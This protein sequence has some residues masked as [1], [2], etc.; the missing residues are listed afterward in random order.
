MPLDK[1]GLYLKLDCG[2]SAKT[3]EAYVSDIK[4]FVIENHTS[5]ERLKPID[6]QNFL[7]ALAQNGISARSLARKLSALRMFFK[8]AVSEGLCESDPTLEVRSAPAGKSLPRTLAP[9]E[10]DALLEAPLR[11]GGPTE[12]IMIRLLYAAG[13]RVTELISLN[14]DQVDLAA[15]V[16]RVHGK[17]DKT[18]IVPID[19]STAS[20]IVQY[21]ENARPSLWEKARDKNK[22]RTLF[23]STHGQSFTR[24]GF[25]KLIKKY[26][27]LAG[28]DPAS[29]S[30][31]VLRHAFATHLL[32]RGM[33]L[34]SLQMLL[35]HADISTTEIYSHLS[36]SH[37]HE[38]M[39]KHHPRGEKK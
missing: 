12:A 35:G 34:R 21:I 9:E 19:A 29:V 32:E 3:I 14:P 2:L 10:V 37:L 5:L 25:W 1:F 18:R 33:N 4:D 11:H 28:I 23:L 15:G 24:Q 8:F 22:A 30:P 26:A 6:I 13:L 36:T 38:M 17:G 7:G 16:V 20:L 31:H 27:L 39:Q